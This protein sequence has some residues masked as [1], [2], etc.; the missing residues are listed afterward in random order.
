MVDVTNID[1]LKLCG[2]HIDLICPDKML[3]VIIL[4]IMLKCNKSQQ[5]PGYQ[6]S[7]I[8]IT[9]SMVSLWCL[10]KN[11]ATSRFMEKTFLRLS[12]K[13]I[14]ICFICSLSGKLVIDWNLVYSLLREQSFLRMM[15][16]TT[17]YEFLWL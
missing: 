10:F 3:S 9:P 1:I 4:V 14:F 17:D 8:L 5:W 13:Q 15:F 2:I 6:F 16:S 11:F 7:R 12:K